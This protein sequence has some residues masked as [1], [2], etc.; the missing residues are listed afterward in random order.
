MNIIVKRGTET[1]K[2]VAPVDIQLH[3]GEELDSGTVEYYSKETLHTTDN[4]E[5]A[6][7]QYSVMIGAV[8]YYFIGVE[9]RALVKILTKPV[10]GVGGEG[11]YKTSVS[12]VE[13]TKLLQ[14][15]MADGFAVTQ[16]DPPTKTL[17]D[18][19]TRVLAHTPFD[20]PTYSLTTDT[21]VVNVLK[22]TISPEFRW[23]TQ[24]TLYEILKDIGTVIDALPRLTKGINGDFTVVTYDFIN[25]DGNTATIETGAENAIGESISESDYNS[26][27]SAVVENLQE[28]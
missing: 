19:V 9:S 12:L 11:L 28:E 25:A 8:T 5:K 16:P 23:N 20:N 18:V 15:V 4:I 26:A 22:A 27:L 24:T 1:L 14:G 2:A 3:L 10:L 21:T 7:A 17:H 13:P 6:L